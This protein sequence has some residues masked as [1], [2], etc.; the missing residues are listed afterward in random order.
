MIEF[1]Y[2]NEYYKSIYDTFGDESIN[3]DFNQ[4]LLIPKYNKYSQLISESAISALI[5]HAS[6]RNTAVKN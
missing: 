5:T 6:Q 1:L 3:G 2:T 4:D